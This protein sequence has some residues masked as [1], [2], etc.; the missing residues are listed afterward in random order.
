MSL[1]DGLF[2]ALAFPVDP[3]RRHLVVAFTDGWDRGSTLDT[4]TLPKL[5]AHSDAVLHVVTWATPADGISSTNAW[6][7]TS[8]ADEIRRRRPWEAS[9]RSVDDAVR[10]TGGT[11]QRTMQAPDALADI[12]SDFRSSYVLHY[13]PR[14]VSASGWHEIGVKLTR[15]GSFTIRARKGYEGS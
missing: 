15:P 8:Y 2:Y 11:L 13:S 4:E 6:P 5:A 12:V 9:F 1:A 14:G 7:P 10:T 3:D